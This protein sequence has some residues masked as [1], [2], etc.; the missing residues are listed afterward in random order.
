MQN[1]VRYHTHVLSA[2]TS[3]Q[4]FPQI[5][6]VGV[7]SHCCS[8]IEW[9]PILCHPMDWSMPH[10]PVLYHLP[11]FAQTHVHWVSDAIQPSHLLSL[12]S[13]PTLNLSQHQDLFQCVGS[14]HQV[15][16]VLEF[17]LQHP[18]NENLELI[19][20]TIDC[21]D[22][23]LC[24]C[25]LSCFSHVWLFATLWT[26]ACQ[27]P[28]SMGFSRQEYWSVLPCPPPGD[29]PDPEIVLTSLI[30]PALAGRFFTTS[31][32]CHHTNMSFLHQRNSFQPLS[33][34]SWLSN[35]LKS[36]H[37]TPKVPV[38]IIPFFSKSKAC[39]TLLWWPLRACFMPSDLSITISLNKYNSPLR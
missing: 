17:Q 3:A 22:L 37:W 14:S 20:F 8:V 10:F 16:R 28:L 32:I 4:F 31:T 36:Y 9:C 13:P 38:L 26:V 18:S 2:S 11:E 1:N 6:V 15:A 30:S 39:S 7:Y 19:S 34:N 12:P 27:A 23:R 25:I 35:H 33:P 29:G 24:V 5:S 21:F